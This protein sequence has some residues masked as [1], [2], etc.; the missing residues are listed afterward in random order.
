MEYASYLGALLLV[1][2]VPIV[3]IIVGVLVACILFTC[4]MV[5]LNIVV[6]PWYGLWRF[7]GGSQ[8][9]FIESWINSTPCD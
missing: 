3:L 4:W 2:F 9:K 7:L 8:S 6:Y 5:V 1:P